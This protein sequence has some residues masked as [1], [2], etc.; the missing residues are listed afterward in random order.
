[1]G[2]GGHWTLDIGHYY[3]SFLHIPRCGLFLEWT[4]GQW[5]F[6]FSFLNFYT[7]RCSLFIQW[8][9]GRWTLQFS[10]LHIPRWIL[11]L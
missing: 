8:T 11:F 5:T 6:P 7:P 2:R 10:F 1:V 4:F 9:F 3:L